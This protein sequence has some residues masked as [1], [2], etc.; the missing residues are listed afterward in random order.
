MS[1]RILKGKVVSA[2]NNKT[3]V[4]EVVRKISTP[5]FWK[6]YFSNKNI[7]PTMKRINLKKETKLKLQ[8]ALLFQKRNLGR[9]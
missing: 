5:F 8:N 3:I 6:S 4:V 9:F 7:M 1:K 2:K